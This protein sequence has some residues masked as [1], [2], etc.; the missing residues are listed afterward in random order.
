MRNRHSPRSRT[1]PSRW[2]FTD[3][4]LGGA[5]P[6]DPLWRA[7]AALP[8]GAGIIFR[9][10]SLAPAPRRALALAVVAQARRR[11][12]LVVLAEGPAGVRA[13]GR[14]HSRRTRQR[15]AKAGLLTASAHS[16]RE[17]VAAFRLGAD[18][19]FLS[20]VFATAS[21]PGGQTLGPLRF[22]LLARGA[23][24]PIV[25]LGGMSEK[26]GKRLR[27]LGASGFAAIDYWA[28]L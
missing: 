12:L 10:H 1:L 9:H 28:S 20:P 26:L 3:E 27:P 21:H 19:V 2:L 23:A 14:H 7:I 22:G 17:M 15:K 6:A 4:R 24:K 25:A 11:H 18:L 16:R 13:D 8:R 5:H